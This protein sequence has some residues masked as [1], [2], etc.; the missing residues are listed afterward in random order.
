LG[1]DT[2]GPSV[3]K[4]KLDLKEWHDTKTVKIAKVK[5]KYVCSSF[6]QVTRAQWLAFCP[7]MTRHFF[8]PPAGVKKHWTGTVTTDGISCSWHIRKQHVTLSSDKST[9]G[10]TI[11]VGSLGLPS[12]QSRPIY[13]GT[14]A[15]DLFI[16]P[17]GALNIVSIDPG[18]VMLIDAVR[19]HAASPIQLPPP[20][21]SDASARAG[22]RDKLKRKLAERNMTHF[23][24]S[25]SH[26]RRECGFVQMQQK[27]HKLDKKLGLQSAIDDLANHTS[28]V[29]T[30]LAYIQHVESKLRT[31]DTM[32]TRMLTTSPR[33]WSFECYRREQLAVHKLSKDLLTGCTG[34]TVIVWGNGSFGPS[35]RGHAPA[36]NKRLRRQLAKYVHVVLSSEYRSSQRSGC[37]R[38]K[39]TDRP[40]PRRVTVKQCTKCKTLVSRDVSAACIIHDIFCYQRE[41]QTER[42]PPFITTNN[43]C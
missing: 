10:G 37:C 27:N 40:S 22:R 42:L 29:C 31:M 11:D 19:S 38:V 5:S 3:S 20:L 7:T 14:H 43:S 32:K 26:W 9:I 36:P 23:S 4:L 2:D 17:L 30:S 13:Y 41:H 33:R 16:S 18:I 15:K 24:L 21:A 6:S 25:N 12:P 8:K 1:S 35:Y 28:R 39:M 34:P